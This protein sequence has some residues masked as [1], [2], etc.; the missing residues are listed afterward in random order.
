MGLN[1]QL[2]QVLSQALEGG[3]ALEPGLADT[4]MAQASAAIDRQETAGDPPVLVVRHGLR[5]LLAHFLR[6]RLRHLVVLSQAEIPDDRILKI[7]NVIGEQ[8]PTGA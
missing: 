5:P 7:T 4:L 8:L 1:S 2:E 3:G 6:R